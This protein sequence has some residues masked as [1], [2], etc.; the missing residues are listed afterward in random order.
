[1]KTKKLSLMV[2]FVLTCVALMVV[3]MGGTAFASPSKTQV[4][5][6]CHYLNVTVSITVTKTGQTT[7]TETY[8][9]SGST[10]FDAPEGWAVFTSAGV[11]TGKQ[12]TGTGSFTLNKDGATYTVYWTDDSDNAAGTPAGKGGTAKTTVTTAA[13][14]ADTTAP[15]NPSNLGATVFSS[16][17]INLAW[18]VSTDATGVTGYEIEKATAIGGPFT[19]AGTSATNS[20]SATGLTPSTAYWFRARAYDAAG[21]NSGYSNVATATTQAGPPPPTGAY[22]QVTGTVHNLAIPGTGVCANC[23]VAHN[24]QG[25]FLW[26]RPVGTTF[27]G[28]KALCYSCHD[29]TI[30]HEEYAFSE[31]YAQ[32]AGECSTCHNPHNNS[33]G[34]FLTFASGA[35]LCN[36]CHS[37]DIGIGHPVNVVAS[38]TPTDATFAPPTDMSGTRLYDAAGTTSGGTSVKCLT[39]HTAHGG[40]A[41]TALNT[42]DYSATSAA[43]CTNCHP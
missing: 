8:S 12:G 13:G 33:Y 19:L 6:D 42:M 22:S 2:V 21:N 41:G 35:N 39:C 15:T 28:I 36:D 1:M 40:F 10:A 14:A 43:L 11:A 20:Y 16:S 32:H 25:D 29:G 4:C 34:M 31:T 37:G 30:A 3:S 17:Q 26:A 9:V 27:T 38:M 7:T 5:T 24:A 18:T 23:H